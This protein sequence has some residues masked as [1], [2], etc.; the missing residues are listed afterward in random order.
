MSKKKIKI[1]FFLLLIFSITFYYFYF[2]NKKNVIVENPEEEK[3]Q[4]SNVLS[5]VNFSSQDDEGNIFTITASEGEIDFSDN[6]IIFLKKIKA[7]IKLKNLEEILISSDFGKYNTLNSHS[8]F[9]K[10][11]LITNKDKKIKSEYLDF[12]PQKNL[13]TISKNVKLSSINYSL[14]ADVIELNIKTKKVEIFMYEGLKKVKI[15]SIK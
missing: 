14:L 12:S 9:S 10:N 11:V 1:F 2:L 13:M 5:E 7:V 4:S 15:K 6:N 8:I 3:I